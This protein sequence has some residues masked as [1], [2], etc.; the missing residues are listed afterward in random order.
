MKAK[1]PPPL[2]WGILFCGKIIYS[3]LPELKPN[4]I[5]ELSPNELPELEPN[6]LL[7]LRPNVLPEWK[8]NYPN[9]YF[10]EW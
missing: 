2:R 6:K 10:T 4:R 5:P 3:E 7:E 1:N 9:L 8:P